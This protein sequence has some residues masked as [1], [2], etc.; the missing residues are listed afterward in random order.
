MKKIKNYFLL[1]CLAS[2]VIFLSCKEEEVDKDFA[3]KGSYTTTTE[4][5]SPPPMAKIKITGTGQSSEIRIITFEAFSTANLTTAP[6]FKL[7]GTVTFYAENGDEFYAT[8][9]GTNTPIDNVSADLVL[10]SVITGGTGMFKNATGGI[11]GHTIAN[12]TKPTSTI[13]FDGFIHF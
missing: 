2:C 11:K 7:E 4:L 13:D 12:N 9:T 6:P 8:F 5:L 10:N 1:M 3:F